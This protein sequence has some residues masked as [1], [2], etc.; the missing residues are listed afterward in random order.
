VT[1]TGNV[2]PVTSSGTGGA[3]GDLPAAP[4]RGRQLCDGPG[5][6]ARPWH[7]WG[8]VPGPGRHWP[9]DEFQGP[10][11]A[12]AAAAAAAAIADDR[13]SGDDGCFTESCR[14]RGRRRPGVLP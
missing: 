11:S 5:F 2:T 14:V 8:R 9:S 10:G 12:A 4:G 13:A 7:W 3:R 1:G 6:R